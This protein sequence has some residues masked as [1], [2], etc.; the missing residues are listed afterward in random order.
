M[1]RGRNKGKKDEYGCL[2]N[3]TEL[4]DGTDLSGERGKQAVFDIKK[5]LITPD[6]LLTPGQS[7]NRISVM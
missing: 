3:K 7:I 6:R 5:I 1:G 4:T 2:R